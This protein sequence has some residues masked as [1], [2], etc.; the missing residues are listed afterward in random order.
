[1]A[2]KVPT[3][4]KWSAIECC[5]PGLLEVF[6]F[7]SWRV[8]TD[9]LQ[10]QWSPKISS[11]K[12]QDFRQLPHLAVRVTFRFRIFECDRVYTWGAPLNHVQMFIQST[13]LITDCYTPA[14]WVQHLMLHVSLLVRN[15]TASS[16]QINTFHTVN[17]KKSTP[18]SQLAPNL[19][20]SPSTVWSSSNGSFYRFSRSY[21]RPPPLREHTRSIMAKLRQWS[22]KMSSLPERRGAPFTELCAIELPNTLFKWWTTSSPS[23]CMILCSRLGSRSISRPPLGRWPRW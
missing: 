22:S 15:Q 11:P 14:R 7:S 2:W 10:R 6:T 4:K 19:S 20:G 13:Q 12:S 18:S 1:M 17:W 9:R 21:D 23:I 5:W 16:E 8:L 3:W